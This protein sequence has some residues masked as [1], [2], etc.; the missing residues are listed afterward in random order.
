MQV[1]CQYWW[2]KPNTIQVKHHHFAAFASISFV[3]YLGGGLVGGISPSIFDP[4]VGIVHGF[5]L[6]VLLVRLHID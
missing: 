3:V 2:K 5:K 1:A 6:T 4:N